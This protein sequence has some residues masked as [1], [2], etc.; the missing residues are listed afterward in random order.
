MCPIE[1]LADRQRAIELVVSHLNWGDLPRELIPLESC[2]GRITSESVR[3][4]MPMP[5]FDRSLRDGYAV[6]SADLVG[7][8]EASPSYLSLGRE[9]IMGAVPDFQVNPGWAH[10][11]HTGGILPKG[12]DCVVMLEDTTPAGHMV[13]VRRSHQR[14]DNVVISGEE[15]RVG[16]VLIGAGTLIKGPHVALL[17]SQGEERVSCLRLRAAVFS[18]GDEVRSL[19]E[20]LDPGTIYDVNGWFLVAQLRQIGI[21]ASYG[22]VLRDDPVLIRDSLL[23]SLEDNQMVLISGGSSV[24]VRDHLEGIFSHTEDPGLL[25]RGVNVQPGKPLLAAVT[26]HGHRLLLGLPGHPLSCAVSFYTFLTPL[27]EMGLGGEGWNATKL[28]MPL[29]KDLPAKPGVEEFVPALVPPDGVEPL[30]S[31]SG[32]TGILS[33]CHGLV[34]VPKDRETLR[35]GDEAE[36]WLFR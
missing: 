8:S 16:D 24:S 28:S 26:H 5:P 22:G 10:P 4:K 23:S 7:A 11:I 1:R 6:R 12:A 34:R 30:M 27:L 31:A 14:G 3:A 13:E 29:L 35:R 2:L 33:R 32:Y 15:S 25:V 36:V 9:V 21:Q 17:A 19:G 18:S 20:T